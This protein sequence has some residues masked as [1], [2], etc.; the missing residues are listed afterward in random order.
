M[1]IGDPV[2]QRDLIEI[3][4]EALPEEFNPIVASVNSRSD[5]ISLHEL[6]SQLL[7]QEAQMKNSRKR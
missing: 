3:V 2:P 6:E 7:T 4:L 1:S 5:I